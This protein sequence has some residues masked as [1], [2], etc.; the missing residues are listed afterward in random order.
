MV[1]LSLTQTLRSLGRRR[2]LFE[3]AVT[4]KR[5]ASVRGFKTDDLALYSVTS[6]V[7]VAGFFSAG[8]GLISDDFARVRK[9]GA[10]RD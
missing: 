9:Q 6:R 8:R 3:S 10:A 4:E 7:R 5:K 1:L 2:Y